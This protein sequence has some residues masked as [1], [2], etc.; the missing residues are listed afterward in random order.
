MNERLKEA[1]G[2]IQAEEDLKDKT[3]EFLSDFS[4]ISVRE[5]TGADLVEKA[6]GVR[7]SVV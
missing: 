5:D 7:C 3:K 4:A 1:F 2:Q 6:T